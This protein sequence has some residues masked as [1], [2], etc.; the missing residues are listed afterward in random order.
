MRW[1]ERYKLLNPNWNADPTDN[2]DGYM[3]FHQLSVTSVSADMDI[4]QV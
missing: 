3:G 2:D 4:G 1:A